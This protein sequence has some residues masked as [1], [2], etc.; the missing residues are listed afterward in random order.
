MSKDATAFISWENHPFCAEVMERDKVY[1]MLIQ[2]DENLDGIACACA[3]LIF[4]GLHKLLQKAILVVDSMMH[5]QT[6]SNK[7]SRSSPTIKFQ[8]EFLVFLISFYTIDHNNKWGFPYVC[9][10]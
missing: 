6:F 5:L 4:Q 7:L 2:P 1:N 10:Q 3:Q 8:G 9:I